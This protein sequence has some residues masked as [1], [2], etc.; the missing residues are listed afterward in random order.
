MV[1]FLIDIGSNNNNFSQIDNIFVMFGGRVFF[2]RQS[3]FL[4]VPTLAD[5]FY[6]YEADFLQELFKKNKKKL[7]K[8]FK[9]HVS[10]Y[11]MTPFH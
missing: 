8:Y 7:T 4:W 5:F 2:N 1:K 3:V 6:S 10:L 11:N 9:V